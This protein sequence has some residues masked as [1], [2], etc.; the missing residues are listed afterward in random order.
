V[1]EYGLRKEAGTPQTFVRG[2]GRMF[3]LSDGT[4]L[5]RADFQRSGPG[6][7]LPVLDA[8]A[9]ATNASAYGDQLRALLDAAALELAE[10]LTPAGRRGGRPTPTGTGELST[11][12]DAPTKT[13]QEVGKTRA[14]P[15]D[16]T[17]PAQLPVPND[18]TRPKTQPPPDLTPP[19]EQPATPK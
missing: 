5:W 4:E 10:E 8:S 7:G 6:Q 11:P 3:L 9:L 15:P 1:E 13:E 16:L 12:Q 19:A 17:A 14:P 2:H 18:R